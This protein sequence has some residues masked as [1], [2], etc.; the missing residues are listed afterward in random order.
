MGDCAIISRIMIKHQMFIAAALLAGVAIGYFVKDEPIPA[1][2]PK[3][4]ETAKRPIADKGE[5]ASVKALRRRIAEL[6]RAL[7]E[8]DEKSEIAISNAVAEAAKTRPP[9]PPRM[10]W[11]E[12]MEEMKK[13][14]P[15]RYTQMTNRMTQWR[16]DRAA[17][18]RGKLGF[19]SSIDTSHMS[20]GAKK[21]HAALQDLIAKREEIEQQL[22]ASDLP[23]EERGKLMEQL[24]DMRHRIQRLNGEERMNLIS[25]VA[26]S[27]GFEGED[28]KE[29]ALTLCDV[30]QAT[31]E[32]FV[33]HHGGHRGPP[34]GGPRGR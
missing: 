19:L 14:E 17:Q 5:E 29:I 18:A 23:D 2:E 21:T 7:A 22:Q 8:K 31:D 33:P 13:N 25:E 26:N 28:A 27:L 12:R 10:N 15:E 32:G 3:V 30:I 1:D 16:H 34:P 9:E 11:R 24:R 20:A 6:E 4:E